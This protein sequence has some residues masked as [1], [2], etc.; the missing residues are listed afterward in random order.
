[1]GKDGHLEF[2]L[3]ER[4]QCH[5]APKIRFL[6]YSRSPTS[7][8]YSKVLKRTA[9]SLSMAAEMKQQA[10]SSSLRPEP[11]SRAARSPIGP[12]AT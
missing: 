9:S 3:C 10:A 8:S 11:I 6:A 7:F 12:V 5:W 4:M 1:M 2:H